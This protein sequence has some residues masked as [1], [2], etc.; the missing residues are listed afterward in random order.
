MPWVRFDDQ[1]PDHPKVGPLSDRLY[2]LHNRAI[3]WCARHTTDGIIR[4]ELLPDVWRKARATDAA[5]LARRGLLHTA[6]DPPCPSPKCPPAGPDG[7][8][9]H[10]YW[11]YQPARV[12]VEKDRRDRAERQRRW[13]EKK[14]GSNT[15]TPNTPNNRNGPVDALA[16]EHGDGPPPPPR[17]E[18]SGARG[19]PSGPTG[20]EPPPAAAAAGGAADGRHDNT[21]TSA[22]AP[23]APGRPDPDQLANTR[24]ALAAATAKHRA[25]AA[26]RADPLAELD[27]AAREHQPTEPDQETP[28][29]A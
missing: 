28:D 2:R 18:G 3:F 5:E 20:A 25:N 17:P 26:R 10:D 19:A 9:V 21:T 4:A 14:R 29:A 13:R 6:D 12:E 23:P 24:R 11:G 16:T 1:Y 22:N 8:V 27:A 15:S 7:W